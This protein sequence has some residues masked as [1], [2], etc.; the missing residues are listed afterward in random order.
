M[1]QGEGWSF[2]CETL[3][4]LT[5][6]AFKRS[7]SNFVFSFSSSVL[8]LSLLES[9]SACVRIFSMPSL[10]LLL[11]SDSF[12]CNDFFKMSLL[13]GANEVNYANIS[14]PPLYMNE[15]KTE[16]VASDMIKVLNKWSHEGSVTHAM[17]ILQVYAQ[18]KCYFHFR[19]LKLRACHFFNSFHFL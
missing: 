17:P 4:L 16:E 13:T 8:L 11:S 7:K 15:K 9:S 12:S 14:N 18:L 1:R 5:S 10:H 3:V 2:M 6:R 19:F